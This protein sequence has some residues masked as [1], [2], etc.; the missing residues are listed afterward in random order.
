[1]DDPKELEYLQGKMRESLEQHTWLG[2]WWR[3][4][5]GGTDI[6]IFQDTNIELDK[7]VQNGD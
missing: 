4:I 7:E 5:T 2:D 1:M 6:K 3:E